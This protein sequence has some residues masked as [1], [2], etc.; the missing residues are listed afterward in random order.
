MTERRL[1]FHSLFFRDES[2]NSQ[3]AVSGRTVRF[4]SILIAEDT[5]SVKQ[6]SNM[7]ILSFTLYDGATN[8]TATPKSYHMVSIKDAHNYTSPE[9]L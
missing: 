6:T 8:P 4:T 7:L 2:K 3:T 9:A 1:R 5:F